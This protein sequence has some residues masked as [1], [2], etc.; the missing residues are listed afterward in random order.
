M[1]PIPFRRLI[2]C[3]ALGSVLSHSA[4]AQ[5]KITAELVDSQRIWD[6][7]PHN[8]FT[9]L[10]LWNDTMY[11]AFREGQ[12]HAGD[13]GV[14]CVISSKDGKKW[15]ESTTL[16][17]PD[18]DLRDAAVSVTPDNR[19][20]VLGGVQ[21]NQ[22]NQRRTGT[23]VSFSDNGVEFS[24]PQI[25]IPPGRWL[26]RLTWHGQHA[27]GVSY[28][29]PD[30][31]PFSSLLKTSNGID[32]ETVTAKL[33]SAGGWPTEAR[34]RF[35]QDGTAYCLHRRDGAE[36]NTAYLGKANAPYSEWTWKDTNIRLGGPNFLQIPS[37][38][39]IAVGRLYDNPVRTSVLALDPVTAKLTPLLDLPSGGDTS[40]AGMIW[41]KNLLWISYYSSHEE[42]TCIYLAKVR[43]RVE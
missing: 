42:K 20:M 12:H 18:L 28:A 36:G 21:Q 4:R 2:L 35:A 13:N 24:R 7:K 6:R 30:G 37:G 16:S 19:L 9:D 27:Y 15:T 25:V 31:K 29:T 38:Q 32:Y 1:H 26:W 41:H 40:Y 14:L 10:A 23:I 3:I 34:I 5:S 8:A 39:W 33:L 22:N 43:I 11:C 17:L